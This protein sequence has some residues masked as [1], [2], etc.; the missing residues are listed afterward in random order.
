MSVYLP[1]LII[2]LTLLL[3]EKD[4]QQFLIFV[5]IGV[6]LAGGDGLI[7]SCSLW[8]LYA[9][10]NI[11]FDFFGVVGMMRFPKWEKKNV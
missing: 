5:L 4:K 7:W 6:V 8:V 11:A 3:F 9:L 1:A 10:V 2:P